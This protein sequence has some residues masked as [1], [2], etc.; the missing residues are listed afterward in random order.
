MNGGA[1]GR[2]SRKMPLTGEQRRLVGENLALVTVH[3]RRHLGNLPA[4]RRDREWEDL[5]QEGCLGLIR[6]AMAYPA[7]SDIPFAAFAL[8]RIHNAVTRALEC[9]FATVYVPRPRASASTAD[10]AVTA[11]KDPDVRPTVRLLSA[12][13]ERCLV[14]RHRHDPRGV[15]HETVGDRIRGKYERAVHDAARAISAEASPR[16]DRAG[17][18]RVLTEERL[19][20]PPEEAR[21]ALHQI[22]RDT[23]SSYARVAQCDKRLQRAIRATLEADPEIRRLRQCARSDPLGSDATIDRAL[24]RD[25]ATE[26]AEAFVH[27][28][29]GANALKRA[30]MLAGLL[31][32]SVQD[33]EDVLRARVL[34]LPPCER[35]RL[36]QQP[37]EAEA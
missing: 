6:A 24:E 22:A 37:V 8:P 25:L 26:C 2:K 30:C 33:I 12:D 17:L 13:L 21:L 32:G 3:L 35:E 34:R 20:V 16:G 28:F 29:R 4:P 7:K 18:V 15:D 9:R 14:D 23:S 11:T 31:R 1:S 36:L 10:A 27:R 19:L 5:F